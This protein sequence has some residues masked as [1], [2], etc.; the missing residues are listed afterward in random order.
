M[1]LLAASAAA[2][3]DGQSG[4]ATQLP[5][6]SARADGAAGAL[7]LALSALRTGIATG[8]Y[9]LGQRL[10]E[11]E[12][13]ASLGVGRSTVREALRRLA[14]EGAVEIVRHRGAVV[15]RLTRREVEDLLMIREALE[16]AAARLAAER[17]DEGENR[18]R[19]TAALE[20]LRQTTAPLD[21]DRYAES[22]HDFHWMIAQISGNRQLESLLMRVQH[23]LA[24]VQFWH[25][26]PIT[27]Y[28]VSM[29]GHEAM[30]RAILAGDGAAA[31]RA[32]HR[33]LTGASDIIRGMSEERF[34][35]GQDAPKD[36]GT[37]AE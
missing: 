28:R 35:T 2:Q 29:R 3:R 17:I 8:R 26:L 20:R 37:P 15:R 10:V 18:A 32:M 23:T 22:D 21:P 24:A 16:A 7:E 34:R 12:L 33:H 13:V 19:F 27:L 1:T 25:R 4:A 6:S 31:A 36:P 9:P 30:A 11:A 5:A 14:G